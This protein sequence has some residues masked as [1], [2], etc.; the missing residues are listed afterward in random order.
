MERNRADYAQ[1]TGREQSDTARS[2]ALN[3]AGFAK[4]LSAATQAYGRRGILNA[5]IQKAG[6]A[7]AQGSFGENQAYFK[8]MSQR[9]LQDAAMS[10]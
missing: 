3:N 7:D 8:T 4:S 6:I 9:R 10:Q 1:F 5:G 2:I